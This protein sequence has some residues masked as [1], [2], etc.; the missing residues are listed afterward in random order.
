MHSE[1]FLDPMQKLAARTVSTFPRKP[2][3]WL[4][5][6]SMALAFGLFSLVLIGINSQ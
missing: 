6:I 3:R 5:L 2:P 4:G 1:A